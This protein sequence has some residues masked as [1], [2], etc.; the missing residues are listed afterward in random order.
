MVYVK[1]HVRF[2][3]SREVL[4][5]R[6]AWLVALLAVSGAPIQAL[7]QIQLPGAFTPSQ[8]GAAPPPSG[9]PARP[10]QAPQPVSIAPPGE[11]TILGRQF[12]RK[13]SAGLM[14]F[15]RKAPVEMSRLVLVGEH[16]DR[17]YEACRVEI[18]GGKIPVKPG[19]Q[20]DGLV[21]FDVE[22][23]ACPFSVDV[24][25]GAVRVRGQVCEIKAASC[26][27]D[28]T[29]IWGP[30]G[31]A[32]N[33]EEA[34]SIERQRGAWDKEARDLFRAIL[35]NAGKDRAKQ[36]QI[37]AEQAAFSSRREEAC[38]DY[39]GEDRHGFCASRVTLARA[40][41]LSAELRG[42]K[43]PAK[44]APKR[45]PAPRPAAQIAAPPPAVQ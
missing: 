15:E 45:K 37:A 28:P 8:G 22:M 26:R 42:N 12:Q 21:S 40:V 24:L 23:E 44:P 35:A 36:K 9:E 34:K 7:A 10:R 25:D 11:E 27:V 3:L 4:K 5:M 33:A 1:V 2:W 18:S 20:A 43:P 31:S 30:S 38:R 6:F 13:G 19:P 39:A 16:V 29:G 41:A 32:I 17:S 14:V